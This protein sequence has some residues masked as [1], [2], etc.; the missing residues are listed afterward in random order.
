MKKWKVLNFVLVFGIAL[1]GC[2]GNGSAGVS[3]QS[4]NNER[5]LVG[6]WVAGDGSTWVFNSNGTVSVDLKYSSGSNPRTGTFKY[7]VS[8]S[9]VYIN[10]K[11][12]GDV[13]VSDFFISNDGATLILHYYETY[14]YRK[15]T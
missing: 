15:S 1:F 9:K 2:N 14:W 11:D 5:R 12:R 13:Y 3:A 8:D 6:T 7:I 4:P 10:T